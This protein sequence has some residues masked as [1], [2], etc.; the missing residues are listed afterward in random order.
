VLVLAALICFSLCV[1]RALVAQ[2]DTNQQP[3][4]PVAA[5]Q[6]K[7]VAALAG[8]KY[9]KLLADISFVG[10]LTGRPE[11]GQLA[12]AIVNQYT[13]GKAATAL[14]KTKPWGVI[15]QTDGAG[16]YPVACLPVANPD[17]VVDVA[18]AHGAEVKDGENG[19]KELVINNR[20]VYMK[21]EGETVFLS[22]APA[23]LSHL[24]A[25]PQ[26]I[27][28]KMVADYDLA[29]AISIKNVP[30]MYRQFAM[31][32]MQAGLQQGMQR[33][34]D[35]SD[36]QFAERQR[37]GETQI[38]Q[39]GRMINEIDSIKVGWAIDSNERRTYFDFT[40]QFIPGS[41]TAQ[42]VAAS[43]DSRTNFAGFFQPDSA[44]TLIFAN[45]TDPKLMAQDIAQF[46]A[47]MRA[48][49]DQ[50]NREIDKHVGDPEA[51]EALKGA[52]DDV[53]EAFEATLKEG[54]ID[55]G[56]AV[57][58][59]PEALT[60]VAGAHVAAPAKIEAALK[61]IEIA[62]AKAPEPRE[63]H[64]NAANHAGV[65]FHTLSLPVP[66]DEEEARRMLGDEIDIAVGIGP[67]AVYVA[68]GRDHIDA[69]SKAIDASN[70]AKGKPVSPFE[71]A[72]SIGPILE[73]I[74]A[75]ENNPQTKQMAQ[76]VADMLKNQAQGRDHIRA[77]GKVIPNGLRYRLEAEEGI[78]RAI[79]V[80]ANQGQQ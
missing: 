52:G 62:L 14:D 22:I 68:V 47:M 24:P 59:S 72:L 21:S 29:A 31:Q 30:E 49:R 69:V 76:A 9:E 79:G 75:N 8:A 1:P 20:T 3:A 64:W 71:F 73:V 48:Q 56:A 35:E 34:P 12:D 26:A 17:D 40:Y 15:V 2:Q 7:T 37:M 10:S 74:A 55:G 43:A 57:S 38:E 23:S 77:V 50:L 16:F 18:K 25:N 4:A 28:T 11:A 45:K 51:R 42:Q 32:A 53:F 63:I 61:K 78:L 33:L 36:E 80:A 13:F 58:L 39:L 6:L 66:S 5:G 41:K 27:L 19:I 54:N 70:A 65:N 67:D 44:A 60:F 46:Q